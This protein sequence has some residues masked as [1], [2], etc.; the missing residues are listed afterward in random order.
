MDRR[1]TGGKLS[2][3]M[4]RHTLHLTYVGLELLKVAGLVWLGVLGLAG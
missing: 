4:P 2:E 1:V 3:S